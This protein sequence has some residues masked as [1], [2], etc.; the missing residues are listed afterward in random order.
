MSNGVKDLRSL[1]LHDI[2]GASMNALVQA[3]VQSARTTMEFIER[4][5]FTPGGSPTA[6]NGEIGQL[7]MVEFSYM[8]PDEN[9]VPAEFVVRMPL[10]A[11][12]PIPGIRINRA[13]LSF[14]AK[15]S[16]VYS[17]NT[18]STQTGETVDSPT[19]LTPETMQFRGSLASSSN[20]SNTTES[21][22]D[23]NFNLEIEAVPPTPG[24]QKL[25]NLMDQAISDTKK[26]PSP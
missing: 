11:I 7:R 6:E 18:S 4:V 3:E 10:L 26:L 9:G 21:S 17:E 14:S 12:L 13:S 8:K 5:G 2:I 24:M 1:P 20:T 19:W 22:F 23:L 25:L 15:I 16:D